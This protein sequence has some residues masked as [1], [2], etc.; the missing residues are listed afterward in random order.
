MNSK[1]T[2]EQLEFAEGLKK[3]GFDAVF[4]NEN[5]EFFTSENYAKMSNSPFECI[6]LSAYGV[7]QSP[8]T[9]E[10]VSGKKRR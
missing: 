8:I 4:I 1:I 9:T 2:Q 10:E 3:Q 7:E 6:D 5:G